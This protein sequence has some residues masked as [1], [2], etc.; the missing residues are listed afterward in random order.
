[1]HLRSDT[2]PVTCTPEWASLILFV[3]IFAGPASLDQASLKG[4]VSLEPLT[5]Q[6]RL[7]PLAIFGM[8]EV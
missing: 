5:V 4:E 8:E 6:L 7:N 1:M 3:T 2:S